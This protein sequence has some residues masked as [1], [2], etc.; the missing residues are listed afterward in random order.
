[1]SIARRA[2]EPR[3]TTG[4]T[5]F[6]V[7]LALFI[8]LGVA[9]I[10]DLIPGLGYVRPG[11]ILVLPMLMALAM[12]V[13]RWQLF[14]ALRTT[15]TKCLVVIT[16]LA[17]ISIP[18]SVWPTSSIQYFLNVMI[19]GLV[20]FIATGVGF[21]DRRTARICILV[22][23][24]CVS[25]DALYLLVG[26]AP[27]IA[28]RPG[29]SASLDPNLS[30]GLFVTTLPFAMAIGTGR[31]R[32]WLVVG[33]ALGLLLV[34]AVVK[35]GSRGGVIGLVAVAAI[36]IFRAAP[37]RRW[38]YIVA[39]AAGAAAFTL[40][41]NDALTQRFGNILERSDYNV[42]E[43][44]GRIQVWTRGMGYMMRRPLIGIGLNGFETAEGVLSGM[45]NQ[46]FGVR[47]MAAHNSF[48][49]I[50]A[51]L[52]VFGLVAFVVALWSAARGCQRIRRR[53][54]ASSDLVHRPWLV[55][56]EASLATTA[57]ASLVGLAVTGFFLSFAYH[58][59]TLFVLAACVGVEA[60]SP[61]AALAPLRKARA[62]RAGWSPRAPV[63]AS[64][65]GATR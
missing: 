6:R 40:T 9:R 15:P 54:L 48:V 65:A 49:Q 38:F 2:P 64:V 25:L 28:G 13:P 11:K 18:V 3:S 51:E 14:A 57:Q 5:V 37:R 16:T 23:V 19:P 31:D 46:G 43:R 10:Q 29:I 12:A 1:M 22:L 36:L 34:A 21:A 55:D 8:A 41:A 58:P 17:L 50:G 39:V 61:Y 42:T 45:V 47:R 27:R 59:I 63:T 44:D 56:H 52:G 53:A 32:R 20:L 33:L 30:A 62:G 35:T 60:G 24:V 26:P 7:C 4:M